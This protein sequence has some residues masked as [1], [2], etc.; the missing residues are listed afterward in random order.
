VCASVA[1]KIGASAQTLLCHDVGVGCSSNMMYRAKEHIHANIF[2]MNTTT[3]TLLPSFL[4]K[5]QQVNGG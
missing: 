4:S 1:A 5:Y 3:I 2:S